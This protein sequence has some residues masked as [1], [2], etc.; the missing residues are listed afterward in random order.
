MK[1]TVRFIGCCPPIGLLFL[2]HSPT[3]SQLIKAKR[4]TC[5]PT[6]DINTSDFN[7]TLLNASFVHERNVFLKLLP[8]FLFSAMSLS[9]YKTSSHKVVIKETC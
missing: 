2:P 1:L 9:N 8:V 3:G 4:E 6:I 5:Q 7:Y